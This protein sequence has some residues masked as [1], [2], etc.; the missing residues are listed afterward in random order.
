M[1]V[2]DG[3]EATRKILAEMPEI[4]IIALSIYTDEGF[5]TGL[6]R[7]GALGHI[8]QGCDCE[9]LLATIRR[10]TCPRR[11]SWVLHLL[12]QFYRKSSV[13]P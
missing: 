10:A 6:I 3:A 4:V 9:E 12:H 13:S 8:L 11:P 2:M 7:T 5:K 1:P